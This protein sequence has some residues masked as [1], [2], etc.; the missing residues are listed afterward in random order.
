MEKPPSDKSRTRITTTIAKNNMQT[1]NI[2][3][4]VGSRKLAIE[5]A[6]GVRGRAE[7][8]K[9]IRTKKKTRDTTISYVMNIHM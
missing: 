9:S 6:E 8:K 3:K 5:A 2:R 1:R 7:A 4:A